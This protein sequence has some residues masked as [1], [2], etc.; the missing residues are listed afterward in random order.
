M[1]LQRLTVPYL[2][3]TS[4]L[5]VH[6]ALKMT[7][8]C[9]ADCYS[10]ST[11]TS[12]SSGTIE[13]EENYL[14]LSYLCLAKSSSN[15]PSSVFSPM[16]CIKQLWRSATA[17]PGLQWEHVYSHLCPWIHY[18]SGLQWEHCTKQSWRSAIAIA[19]A[20]V[21]AY[22]QLPLPSTTLCV[23]SSGS[24]AQS[25]RGGPRLH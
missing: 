10:G 5:Q 17:Q 2:Y 25:S 4:S 12:R 1:C 9:N 11:F 14:P 24:F 22:I 21:G 15:Y 19:W 16:H 23:G 8:E 7:D 20:P 13:Q 3:T 6:V 18:V